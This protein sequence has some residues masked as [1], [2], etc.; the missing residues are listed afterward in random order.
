MHRNELT[1]EYEP[2]GNVDEIL[3]ENYEQSVEKP[4]VT[5]LTHQSKF[6]PSNKKA[7]ISI[8]H[9]T[10]EYDSDNFDSPGKQSIMGL[11]RQSISI[12]YSK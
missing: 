10:R 5:I 7:G 1:N 9:T 2:E 4:S 12:Q 8:G 3:N 6:E 11:I